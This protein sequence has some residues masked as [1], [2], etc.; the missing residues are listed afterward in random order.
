[1]SDVNSVA[2]YMYTDF[3]HS[4]TKTCLW[5]CLVCLPVN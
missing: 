2:V 4:P 3:S 1:M 5:C